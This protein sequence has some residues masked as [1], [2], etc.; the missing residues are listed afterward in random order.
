MMLP[1]AGVMA[2]FVKLKNFVICLSIFPELQKTTTM[3]Y[4][5][6]KY[7]VILTASAGH[8]IAVL[9]MLVV[10]VNKSTD[11]LVQEK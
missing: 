5:F 9:D 6:Y 1:I 4:F 7:L 8:T 11:I 2:K 3:R 10:Q